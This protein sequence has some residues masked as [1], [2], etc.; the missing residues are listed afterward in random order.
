MVSFLFDVLHETWEI[1]ED[2]SVFLLFGFLL[3]GL[4]AVL[5][6]G[7]LLTRLV[8]T[9]KIKSVLWGSV[10][11][12]PI[13]L[14]S[15][16]VLPTA[17]GLRKEGATPGAT[18]AFLVATPE[19]GVDSISLTY[20]LTDPL[21][22]VFRPVAGVATAIVAGLATNLFG[23]PHARTPEPHPTPDT[24]ACR[25]SDQCHASEELQRRHDTVGHHHEHLCEPDLRPHPG[26]THVDAVVNATRRIIR[27]GFVE[28]LDDVSW[29]LALGI[30]LSAVA[31]VAIPEQLFE[32]SWGAGVISMLLMFVLSIPLYTCASSSTPMAAALALKGLSPGA[33]LVFLL[34]GPA[35]NISS[36][37]VLLKVLGRR[38]VAAYLI[39]VAIFTLAA[40]FGL[41]A[42]YHAWSLDP[43]T[44]FGAAAGFVPDVV[45]IAGAVLLSCLLILSMCRTHVPEEWG[46]L[47][48]RAA[49]LTGIVVTLRGL[50][51][52][53]AIAAALLWLGSGFF[54]VAPGQIG[55][56]IQFG[57]ILAS[58]LQPGLHFRWP[59]PVE[60]HRLIVLNS[61]RRIEF[62]LA[63]EQSRADATRAQLRG[64]LAFGANPAPQVAASGVWFQKE[65]MPGD[66]FL[67]TGDANLINLRS[68]AHYRVKD[69]LAFAYHLAEPEALVRST[70]LAAL[71]HA[72]ATRPI[73]A[74]YTTA[75]ED[76][77]RETRATAQSMLDRYQAGIEVL[78]IS[79]L[80]DHP[81]DE[82]HDAFRDVASALEDKQ[83]TINLANVF[84]VEKINQ[85]KGEAAA[86]TEGALSFK[87]QRIATAQAESN[88]FALRLEAYERAPELTKFRLQLETL[89]Q[90]LPGMRKFVRPASGEVKDL[91]M[92]LV[93]PFGQSK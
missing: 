40:G 12:A 47:R 89:E 92:W 30:V 61:V 76:I 71:R 10:L 50:G 31:V 67:L 52:T 59:W 33:V 6:P 26:T 16:G 44:T 78:S 21:M 5:A 11:G 38:V 24:T 39:A 25:D 2:A 81:P 70:I 22:T 34:A 60:S 32:G 37:V 3:A 53:A 8:G 85:A 65:M 20:A 29:W 87:E 86:M 80:Y 17:L 18:I 84:A 15:C 41:N 93:Q 77:E 63:P 56:R 91:D 23:A 64:R 73:D 43:R 88:A 9:G 58:D 28:L 55:M 57:R 46:W 75:R 62:G 4:L 13:P 36:I 49:S 51:Y 68:T 90:V 35:T 66:S 69:A 83:R 72:V 1:L 14:C 7:A 45:K 27:Y 74:V 54:T 48:D 42:I 82:V 79:L 19:T